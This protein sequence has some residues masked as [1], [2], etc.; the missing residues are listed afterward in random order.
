MERQLQDHEPSFVDAVLRVIE[1]G[2]R[3][4]LDR[5][6]LARLDVARLASRAVRGTAL[7]AIGAVLIVGGWFATLALAVLCLRPYL[8]PTASLAILAAATIVAGGASMAIGLRRA[9]VEQLE[10]RG[11]D[12]A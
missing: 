9:R 4:V 3:L 2:Q 12:G 10:V 8:S 6:D 5:I 11:T 1:A 7:V